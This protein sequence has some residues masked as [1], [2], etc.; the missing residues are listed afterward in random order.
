VED[1]IRQLYPQFSQLSVGHCKSGKTN[2]GSE[3]EKKEKTGKNENRICNNY[4]SFSAVKNEIINDVN[5][6]DCF[7]IDNKEKTKTA[8]SALSPII[9]L[10]RVASVP[11]NIDNGDYIRAAGLVAVAGVMLP[12]DVRDMKD[13]WNQV[14]HNKQPKYDYK[15]AQAPFSFF[16]GTALEPIVNKMGKVG[17]KLHQLDI[18]M[19]ETN[20][21]SFI[22]RNLN[23]VI[24]PFDSERTGRKVPQIGI[25]NETGKTIIGEVEVLAFNIKG[26]TQQKLIGRALLRIPVFS[27]IVLGLLELPSIVKKINNAKTLNDKT[28]QGALQTLKSSVNLASIIAGI[29]LIGALFARKGPAYSVLGM[30]IGSVSGVYISKTVQKWMDELEGRN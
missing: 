25:D 29:S 1:R 15:N 10:R 30:G 12:E 23:I 6:L 27:V 9:P 18:P 3:L 24:N 5:K 19:N 28:R 13:A 17:V 14:V 8:F 11:D 16:R 7:I 2:F 21:G 22:K 20:F 4:K 26:K